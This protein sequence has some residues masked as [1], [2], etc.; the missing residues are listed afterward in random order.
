MKEN[1]FIRN[2]RQ[3]FFKHLEVGCP[4]NLNALPGTENKI[5]KSQVI[6]KKVMDFPIQVRGIFIQKTEVPLW[7]QSSIQKD[8]N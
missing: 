6:P 2:G 5:S 4:V 8:N 7:F 3:L 1:G